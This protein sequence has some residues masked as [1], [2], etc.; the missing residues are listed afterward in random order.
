M[1]LFSGSRPRLG[2]PNGRLAPCPASP[3]CVSSQSPASDR[4]HHVAPFAFTG[5][6]R[7]AWQILRTVVE[8]AERAQI[9][10][11]EPGYLHAEFASRLFGFVDDVEFV[12]DESARL[13]H[14]RSASRL[15]YGDLGAN[16]GRIEALRAA[17]RDAGL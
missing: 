11:S 8:R 16:R 13:I 4:E 15:G 7:D 3:N 9:V 1:G 2:A 10:T 6:A 14:V 12:L 5:E 17:L